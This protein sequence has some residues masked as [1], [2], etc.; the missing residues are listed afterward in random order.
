MISRF[1]QAWNEYPRQ[2]WLLFFGMLFSTIGTSMIWPFL[3]IYL[4]ETLNVKLTTATSLMSLNAGMGLVSSFI[5]G[6]ITDKLGRKWVMVISLAM[7][8][9][10]NIFMSQ[11]NTL[12]AFAILMGIQGT[13][14][15]LYRV[16]ADAMVSDLIPQEK[17]IDAYSLLRMANNT[18][19]ALGPSIG[20]FVAASSY[21]TA[22][23]IASAG[24]LLYSL[25]VMIFGRETLPERASTGEK[26]MERFGGYGRVLGNLKYMRFIGAVTLTSISASIMW[27]L[28]SVYAKGNYG[29]TESQYGPI[30]TTNALMVV[31]LQ[32]AIT[33][34]FKRFNP[35]MVMA[36]GAFLYAVGTGSVGFGQGFWWFWMSMVIMTFGELLLVP[37]SST[38][39][40]N[41]APP[42]M[43]GR[44]MSIYSLTWG[45]ATGLGPLFAGFMGDHFGPQ[46]IWWT[47]GAAGLLSTLAFL[48]LRQKETRLERE[49]VPG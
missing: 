20:G 33:A 15:P 37:T 49:A 38:Y 22:F 27:V 13:F 31:L 45:I 23:L 10:V 7:V 30:P 6:A 47:A 39:A 21:T 1:R 4:T 17:R 46:V 29:V 26:V 16:A 40:A 43:R 12:I 32:V 44:Y 42:D 5:A 19:I 8:G 11:A 9:L 41:M 35:L 48:G 18:G 34:I 3:M 24:L 25:A 28:L 14:N 2:F 36:G